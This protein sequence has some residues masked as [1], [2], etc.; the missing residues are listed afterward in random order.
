M[1]M[2]NIVVQVA[3]VPELIISTCAYNLHQIY[4]C[5][6]ALLYKNL[7]LPLIQARTGFWL[8]EWRRVDTLSWSSPGTGPLV[9][10]E[11]GIFWYDKNKRTLQNLSIS[12]VCKN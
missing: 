5:R 6:T 12:K 7:C 3:S 1:H 4:N 11:T 10:T 9:M 8:E 2:H